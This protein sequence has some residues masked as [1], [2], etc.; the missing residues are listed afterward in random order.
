M[1]EWGVEH[2]LHKAALNGQ[3]H[4]MRTF[5]T[6]IILTII[7]III[8]GT[9]IQHLLHK[10]IEFTTKF[11]RKVLF[12]Y[13]GIIPNE[14]APS[15]SLWPPETHCHP[16]L[17]GRWCCRAA[18]AEQLKE[19]GKGTKWVWHSPKLINI[20]VDSWCR[21]ALGPQTVAS[22]YIFYL[23]VELYWMFFPD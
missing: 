3:G 23:L 16:A 5:F 12:S 4:T 6:A 20:L 11:S 9:S 1:L 13:C 15:P 17:W 10:K 21:A 2:Q 22:L 19:T 14:T 7:V 8:S 18:S